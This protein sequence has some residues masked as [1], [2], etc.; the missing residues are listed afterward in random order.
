M[1]KINIPSP[2]GGEEENYIELNKEK[3]VVVIHFDSPLLIV[4][5]LL[6]TAICAAGTLAFLL[7]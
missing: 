7:Y 6:L 4:L 5:F 3:K 1:T 2:E